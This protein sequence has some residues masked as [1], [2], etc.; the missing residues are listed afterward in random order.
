ME[1]QYYNQM[2]IKKIIKK[3]D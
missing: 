1:I 3:K 2:T